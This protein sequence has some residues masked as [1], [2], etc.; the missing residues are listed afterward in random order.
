MDLNN[1]L[2][3]LTGPQLEV[4]IRSFC[5]YGAVALVMSKKLLKVQGLDNQNN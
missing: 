1:L 4:K 2:L 5:N 3:R